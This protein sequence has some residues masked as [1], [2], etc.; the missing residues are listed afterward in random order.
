MLPAPADRYARPS[1]V[2]ASGR[3]TPTAT[4][5]SR[6]LPLIAHVSR[7]VDD[8]CGRFFGHVRGSRIVWGTRQS[9]LIVPD[10]LAI[11]T[12]EYEADGVWLEVHGAVLL[13]AN[14][15]RLPA[16]LEGPLRLTGTWGWQVSSSYLGLLG[17]PL[18]AISTDSASISGLSVEPGDVL[19]IDD[20]QVQ[21]AD[22]G[23]L[24]RGVNGS[25]A[26]AHSAGAPVR[27][28]TYPG[29]IVQATTMQVIRVLTEQAGGFAGVLAT[30]EVGAGMPWQSTYPLIRDML[31]PYM[32]TVAA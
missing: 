22:D 9:M 29:A 25:T 17:A 30:S 16:P 10:C 14:I 3:L 5:D 20:E 28:R 12:V 21:V 31:A 7:S 15:L 24:V 11:E 26:A 19:L 6:L 18:D 2:R 32:V 27:L 23:A 13:D 1:Y 8:W 4:P